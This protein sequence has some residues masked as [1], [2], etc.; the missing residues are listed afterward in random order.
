MPFSKEIKSGNYKNFIKNFQERQS[1]Y[2]SLVFEELSEILLNYN[3]RD[4]QIVSSGSYW[5]ANLEIDILT[6][7]DK[8]DIFVAECKWRNHKIN[9]KEFH[10]LKE[11]CK[12]LDI[13]PTQILFFSKR[14]FSKELK[15]LESKEL[16]LYS[17]E[18]FQ[19]LLKNRT[20]NGF[21]NSLI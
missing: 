11:K 20:D 2:T 5:D 7:T 18:D 15:S 14:G 9:K 4:A 8:D 16:A 3:I 6:I 19:V 13:E 12:K 10:K 21:I 17:S 1:S